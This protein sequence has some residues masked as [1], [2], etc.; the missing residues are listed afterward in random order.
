MRKDPDDDLATALPSSLTVD[1]QLPE[2]VHE[3][4]PE[5]AVVAL[6]AIAVTP[7]VDSAVP[8]MSIA[9][10]TSVVPVIAADPDEQPDEPAEIVP[11]P[12]EVVA[13][14]TPAKA[15]RKPQKVRKP[16][17]PGRKPV[18]EGTW[19]ELVYA[20]TLHLVNL[21]DSAA[22]RERK[23]LD[24]RIARPF[25]D[26][27]RFIPVLSRKGGVGKTTVTVL[28]GMALADVRDD[29]VLAIDAN[30][31]RG[32]LADRVP[33]QTRSTVRDV[34]LHAPELAA[35]HDLATHLSRDATGLDVAASDSDPLL[36]EAF[37][38]GGY[39]VV[40][41][42]AS[43]HYGI[44]VT[45]SGTGV[46][47][48]VMRAA[49]QRADAV[50]V[51]SGGSIDEARLASETL[52]WLEANGYGA[53]AANAVVAL[54]ASTQGTDLD[55]LH[56]IEDHFRSRVR[57]VVRIPYDPELAAGSVVRYD[58]LRPFTRD[59]ARQLAALVVDGLP[60]EGE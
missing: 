6:D 24:A 14:A 13:A 50:V 47:H 59:S 5:E 41:D 30:P 42:L 16:A 49:L 20:A 18:P 36:A 54:N 19:P 11:L 37:D 39:N 12:E 38:D 21:G 2:P 58:S 32:T 53:L 60:G 26:R 23:E 40:A 35:H 46:V 1:L 8:T 27:P 48:S 57:A 28:L 17:K 43:P 29:Y 9:I 4:P 56:D 10:S 52:T 15:A 55:K 34:V 22:V 45:D 31:D 7:A 3:A 44:V 25:T 33:K 51:V